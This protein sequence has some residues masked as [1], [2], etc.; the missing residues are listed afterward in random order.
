MSGNLGSHGFGSPV[1]QTCPIFGPSG[2][3]K[4]LDPPLHPCKILS[5]LL[6]NCDL[7]G[8]PS[9]FG[10]YITQLGG[11]EI[12]EIFLGIFQYSEFFKILQGWSLPCVLLK[13]GI[14]NG[15]Q[16][17][18]GSSGFDGII[19]KLQFELKQGISGLEKS[20]RACPPP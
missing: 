6:K 9:D 7:W 19:L 17:L 8:G 16:N 10:F 11:C 2:S 20:V 13:N 3:E 15:G 1:Y 4:I 5:S 18:S 12:F 14:K